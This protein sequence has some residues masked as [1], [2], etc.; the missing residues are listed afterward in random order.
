M[1]LIYV[2]KYRST[3]LVIV[4]CC[5][6]FGKK[7]GIESAKMCGVDYGLGGV[8]WLGDFSSVNDSASFVESEQMSSFCNREEYQ[9]FDSFLSKFTTVAREFF[10]PPERYKFGL[11]SERS[12]LS[13]FGIEDSSTWLAVLY[14]SGCPGCSK[15]IKKEEDLKNA[16]QMDNLIVTEVSYLFFPLDY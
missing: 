9:L 6:L 13:T 4:C 12:M 16:L 5:F 8:P 15:I 3:S 14:L 7:Q 11:V 2:M 10:L 1:I